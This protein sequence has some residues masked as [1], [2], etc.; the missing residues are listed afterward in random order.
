MSRGKERKN[1]YSKLSWQMKIYIRFTARGKE[2]QERQTKKYMQKK[3]NRFKKLK[4]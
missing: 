1:R 3:Y 4:L 2:Q